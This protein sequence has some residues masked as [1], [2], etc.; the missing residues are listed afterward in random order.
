MLNLQQ[1]KKGGKSNLFSY[2]KLKGR[3]VEKYGTQGK[4]AEILGI[5][6]TAMSKKMNCETGFSQEDII[7]WSELLG[8]KPE[9]YGEY[10]FA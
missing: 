10:F 5:S 4:F 8:I 1:Q 6:K 7:V 3:I 2:N 9:E